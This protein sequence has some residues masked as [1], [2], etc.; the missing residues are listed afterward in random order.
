M[1]FFVYLIIIPIIILAINYYVTNPKPIKF[2]EFV[3]LIFKTLPHLWGYTFFLYYLE[4]EQHIQT[5]GADLGISVFLL[6]ISG[7]VIVLRIFYWIK[8]KMQKKI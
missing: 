4:R 8:Y 7:V 1:S 6:P 2:N 5:Y 3:S